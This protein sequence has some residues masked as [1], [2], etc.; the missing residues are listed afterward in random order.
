MNFL[1]FEKTDGSKLNSAKIPGYQLFGETFDDID[2]K[3]TIIDGKIKV[4]LIV[5]PYFT[6][7]EIDDINEFIKSEKIDWNAGYEFVDYY[8]LNTGEDLYLIADKNSDVF[9]IVNSN[10]N[11]SLVDNML[12]KLNEN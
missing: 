6:Q 10:K 3:L 4:D 8:D 9:N 1:H 7:G 12:K 2:F 5:D 11:L